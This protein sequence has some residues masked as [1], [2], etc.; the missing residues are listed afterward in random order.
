MKLNFGSSGIRGR[1]PNP[2][3]PDVAFEL[4]KRLTDD[5]GDPIAL[6]HDTRISSPTLKAA[7]LSAALE[8]GAFVRDYGLVPTPVLSYQ[9][10]SQRA[11]CGAMITA[12][13]NPA[14]YNGFK[15]F[16]SNGEALGDEGG[17]HLRE[18]RKV[19]N[20]RSRLRGR[21]E[22]SH[23]QEYEDRLS[24]LS[25]NHQWKVILDPGNG[26]TCLL[27]SRVYM[28]VLSH[29]TVINSVPDGAFPARGSEPTQETMKML[30]R[31]VLETGAD[32]GIGFDGDGDRMF[33]IDE[34][35]VCPLQDRVLGFYISYLAQHSKGPFLVPLDASMAIDT[36]AEKCN[37][38]VIRGP[39]G[40]A[41]LLRE[42]RKMR[43]TFAGE[44][45]GAWIHPQFNPC[46]DGVLS[47]LL[48][49]RAVEETQGPVSR[50]LRE[51]PQYH[52]LRKSLR[53]SGGISKSAFTFLAGQLRKLI[54]EGSNITVKFGLRIS[55]QDSWVLVRQSG[56]EP[57][58]RVTCES[59]QAVD[60]ER[61]MRETVRAVRRALKSRNQ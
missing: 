12:S 56:T 47:G 30:G 38:R 39:V 57:V 43:G 13:H 24:E 15:V 4:A 37:A 58:V 2:V 8:S 32:A 10:R 53:L 42:M 27:A 26:A 50:A 34:K 19:T 18:G 49:L 22:T 5:V 7:F 16:N 23:T 60:A 29:V 55:S 36:V 21:V 41:K 59:K 48:F 6:G 45:S 1:Y 17:L 11:R 35:G 46:P 20:H 9:T 33:M 61:I 52:M 28:N 25:F 44:P 3:G 40:D 31:A 54:G 14:E 51:V